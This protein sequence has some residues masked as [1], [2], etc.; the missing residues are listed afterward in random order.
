MKVVSGIRAAADYW[1]YLPRGVAAI[2]N[3]GRDDGG[4]AGVR[5]A[6]VA[7]SRAS[8]A[9]KS[10]ALLPAIVRIFF[11]RALKHLI[12]SRRSDIGNRGG[13]RST[14]AAIK[15]AGEDPENAFARLSIS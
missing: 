11:Q 2:H 7:R 15:L 13:G 1:R 5:A 3:A 6:A 9:F 12:Q 14:T 8:A 4:V 10:R